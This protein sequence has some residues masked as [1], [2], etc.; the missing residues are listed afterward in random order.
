MRESKGFGTIPTRE[1]PRPTHSVKTG[2]F[3]ERVPLS[4]AC[5]GRS[6]RQMGTHLLCLLPTQNKERTGREWNLPHKVLQ[7]MARSPIDEENKER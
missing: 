6:K 2:I 4:C 1:N 7:L 5:C 3:T